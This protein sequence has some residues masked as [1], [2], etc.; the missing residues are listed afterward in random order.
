MSQAESLVDH[1]ICTTLRVCLDVGVCVCDRWYVW[2]SYKSFG[3]NMKKYIY[4]YHVYCCIYLWI[5]MWKMCFSSPDR[6]LIDDQVLFNFQPKMPPICCL[7][8]LKCQDVLL[9]IA[10]HDLKLNTLIFF[11][12]YLNRNNSHKDY[13]QKNQTIYLSFLPS[14]SKG[15]KL[16]YLLFPSLSKQAVLWGKWGPQNTVRSLQGGRA[17]HI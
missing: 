7:Q 9:F 16:R 17:R 11:N 2:N 8:P 6:K 4:I 12:L 5:W 3:T 15:L 10:F 13:K 14:H 1:Y